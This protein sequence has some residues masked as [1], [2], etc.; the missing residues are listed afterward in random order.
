MAI[1]GMV[2]AA[3]MSALPSRGDVT[4]VIAGVVFSVIVWI[5][6]RY[7]IVPL[8]G[9]EDT[10]ITTGMVSSQW[11]WWLSFIVGGVGLGASLDAER[12]IEPHWWTPRTPLAGGV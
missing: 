12:R 7:A 1:L 5:I 4:T 3:V 9:G 2:F 11:F 6:L 8:N 10:L